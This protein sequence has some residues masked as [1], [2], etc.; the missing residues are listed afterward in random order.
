MDGI[1]HKL[2]HFSFSAA[3]L[4][5]MSR[6]TDEKRTNHHTR[7]QV[8]ALKDSIFMLLPRLNGQDVG[9]RGL[10]MY[11]VFASPTSTLFSTSNLLNIRSDEQVRRAP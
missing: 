11:F 8:S 1:E 9:L 7:P 5:D 10:C 4:A 3:V 2:A 6:R